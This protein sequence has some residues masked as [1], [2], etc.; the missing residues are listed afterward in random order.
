MKFYECN[1]LFL[2]Y[3]D[4][5]QLSELGL[6][7]NIEVFINFFQSFYNFVCVYKTRDENTYEDHQCRNV[8]IFQFRIFFLL[9][10]ERFLLTA[11]NGVKCITSSVSQD[12]YDTDTQLPPGNIHVNSAFDAKWC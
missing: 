1:I 8:I 9:W 5:V 10:M 7:Q 2:Y 12:C 6:A 11:E 3:E 4:D